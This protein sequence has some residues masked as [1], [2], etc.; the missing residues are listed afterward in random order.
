MGKQQ[1]LEI[2]L[3]LDCTSSMQTWIERAKTT[4]QQIVQ[5][6]VDSA[7]GNLQVRVCF[8]GY[9]DHCDADRFTIHE[10]TEDI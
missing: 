6:V 8:V 1:L 7:D 3:L 2:G 9:R 4:L 10:F 5:N